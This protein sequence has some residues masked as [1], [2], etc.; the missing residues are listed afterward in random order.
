MPYAYCGNCD[1]GLEDPT[2]AE[3]IEMKIECSLCG[4][5]HQLSHDEHDQAIIQLEERLSVVE[6]LLGLVQ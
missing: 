6:T 3:C 1:S 2:F 4:K 5:D